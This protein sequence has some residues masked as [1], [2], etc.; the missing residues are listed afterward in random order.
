MASE[1]PADAVNVRRSGLWPHV[2][3]FTSLAAAVVGALVVTKTLAQREE[4]IAAAQEAARP[5][6]VR[7]T[8]ITVAG[9][10]A[11][12]DL[13]GAVASFKQQKVSLSEERTL[14]A[15]VPEARSLIAELGIARLPTYLVTGEVTRPN[16]EGFVKSNGEIKNGT[17]VFTNVTPVFVD[18]A[19]GQ[20][21]G[22][23]AVTYLTDAGCPQCVDPKLTVAAYQR[24]GVKITE[25]K[26]IAWNSAE[27][28]RLI[29]QYRIAKLPTFLMSAD[30]SYYPAI[31]AA[32]SRLGTVEPDGTYVA[33]QLRPPYR[34]VA[35]GQ[36]VGLVEVV[37][38]TDS[39]CPDCYDARDVHREI[40]TQGFGV[41]IRSERTVDA[42]TPAGRSL[43]SKYKITQVPTLLISPA[44][45]EYANLTS[46]WPR[47]GTTETD[48]WYVF[49]QIV[50]LGGVTY[51]DL[52]S[53][54]VIRPQPHGAPEP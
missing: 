4:K 24:A 28:K 43:V 37:Y 10:S 25:E 35:Q 17:F 6:N 51:K 44:V 19:S 14:A 31:A 38:L 33:R 13:A 40:L 1:P 48:G 9:C 21:R 50:Q 7:L 26:A 41:G 18:P 15:D 46:V 53:N 20:E 34:D 54:Q 36:V 27:G 49:R 12:F 45:D 29:G 52:S 39:R 30:T 47:V 2:F 8:K 11:C 3:L 5:A 22:K 16:L 23:V 42:N 32:W